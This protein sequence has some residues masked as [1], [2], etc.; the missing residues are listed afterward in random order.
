MA[1]IIYVARAISSKQEYI[2]DFN[3]AFA[4]YR[5]SSDVCGLIAPANLSTAILLFHLYFDDVYR[6]GFG[7]IH[8]VIA[9]AGDV[10]VFDADFI[11]EG[12]FQ[13]SFALKHV[14]SRWREFMD[15]SSDGGYQ[16]QQAKIAIANGGWFGEG[17]AAAFKR[18][19]L[20]LFF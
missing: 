16:S 12:L 14:V 9:I 20:L 7:E 6:Q 8:F 18:N 19:F 5:A 2:K 11:A 4:Y 15:A 1:L 17:L 3:S 13:R 10:C